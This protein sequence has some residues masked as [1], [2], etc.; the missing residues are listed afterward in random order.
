[1]TTFY[2]KLNQKQQSDDSYWRC[3]R[4]LTTLDLEKLAK[5]KPAPSWNDW[6]QA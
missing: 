1:M 6:W 5:V 3:I 4:Q 2:Q